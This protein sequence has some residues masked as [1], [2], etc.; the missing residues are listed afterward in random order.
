MKL[1]DRV[2]VGNER[3]YYWVWGFTSDGAV[4]IYGGDRDPNGVRRVRSIKPE[5]LRPDARTLERKA[6]PVTLR[7]DD[8]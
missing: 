5:L 3:G 6:Y 1:H 7:G 2:R 4:T 8:D